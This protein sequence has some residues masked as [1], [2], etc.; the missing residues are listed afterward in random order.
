MRRLTRNG[1]CLG[2]MLVFVGAGFLPLP[3]AA[4][5][6]EGAGA[7]LEKP[8]A[9]EEKKEEAP[10]TCGPLISDTCIPI[11]THH[12]SL[13]VLGALSIYTANFSPNWRRVSTRGNF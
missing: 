6:V 1:V 11:E 3:A 9:H 7:L 5:G 2:V 13:Q 10:T 8:P 4:Q 12:A